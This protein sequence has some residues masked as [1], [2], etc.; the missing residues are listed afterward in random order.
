MGKTPAGKRNRRRSLGM[1][2][3]SFR[4]WKCQRKDLTEFGT[5]A[6][7]FLLKTRKGVDFL[8]GIFF[9]HTVIVYCVAFFVHKKISEEK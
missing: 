7:V 1:L 3:V 5:Y 2:N 8:R 6:I 4:C 9:R